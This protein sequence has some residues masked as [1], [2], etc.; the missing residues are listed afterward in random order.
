MREF[1]DRISSDEEPFIPEDK[2]RRANCYALE[3][4][5]VDGKTFEAAEIVVQS[6]LDITEHYFIFRD[7][8]GKFIVPAAGPNVLF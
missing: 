3:P 2:M 6:T 7:P 5:V 8:Q 4:I 1:I